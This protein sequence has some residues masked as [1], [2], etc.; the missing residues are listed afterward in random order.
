MPKLVIRYN[1]DGEPCSKDEFELRKMNE[2]KNETIDVCCVVCQERVCDY[3]EEPPHKDERDEAVCEY[4]WAE[5]AT[6]L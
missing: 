4:C 5:M 1:I 3:E 2:S 6:P